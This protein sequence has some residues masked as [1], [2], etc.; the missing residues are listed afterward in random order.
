MRSVAAG[1]ILALMTTTAS[2]AAVDPFSAEA[3]S[4]L[5]AVRVTPASPGEVTAR[6][7]AA[8]TLAAK[9][10][11]SLEADKAPATATSVFGPYDALYN[12]TTTT[13]AEASLISESNPSK[14]IR[15]AAE[16]C[17]QRM[18]DLSTAIGLSRPLY[19]RLAAI[20]AT[21]LDKDTRYAL[22]RRLATYRRA[23]VDKDAATRA[24]V[25]AL[26]N[27]ITT[28]GLAFARNIRELKGDIVLDSA[29]ELKG[30]PQ[31]YIDA[32]KPG[33]DGKIHISTDYPDYVPLMEYADSEAVRRKAMMVY[34]NRAWPANEAVLKDL[35]AKRYELAR[36]LGFPSY[37]HLIT[38]DK[39]IR[40]PER[41]AAFL[42]DLNAAAKPGADADY[43]TLLA[44]WKQIQP[45]ATEVPRWSTAYLNRLIRKE[46]YQVDASVVRT[47]FTYQK[48]RDGIFQLVQDLFGVEI[49]PWAGAP[50]WDKSVGAYEVYDQGKLVGR[51]YLDMHPREGKFNHAAQFPIRTGLTD[52]AV[53]VGA[54]LCNFPAEGPMAHG[55]VETFLHEFGHLL[56]WLYSGRQTYA[57]QN[58]SEIEW[59]FVEAPSQLLEEWV[60]D[61]ETLKRFAS[62][63]AGKPIPQDLVA[64][65]NAARHFGEP[66]GVKTQLAYS[67]ISLNYYNR[68]PAQVDPADMWKTQ[69]ER[70]ALYPYVPGTHSYASFGHLT[71][72]SAIYYTYMWSK[73]ISLDLFTAFQKAGLRDVATAR[74]YREQVL[75]PGGSASANTLIERFLGRPLS[76]EPFKRRLQG[77]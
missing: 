25:E 16:A 9:I 4:F 62:D 1:L 8:A 11:A 54:L 37:A 50:V 18:N 29:A 35:L 45:T 46:K 44:R 65:M 32:H 38:E 39:M 64:K 31:D 13:G 71:D 56:H 40:T 34:D 47:Y 67:A 33:A 51:F 7:D 61:Y 66:G 68:D 73:A 22:D 77:K 19:D 14:P 6:C 58:F 60:W 57:Q 23:G 53:P 41:A 63:A 12:V 10:R 55:D 75:A 49:R 48:S 27:Q 69:Y 59:D 74:R 3:D 28:V 42:D 36:M 5:A 15:D 24:K 20:D 2:A 43:Q 70:Y 30:L 17:A 26:Q 76:L 21:R 72:Y 52:R